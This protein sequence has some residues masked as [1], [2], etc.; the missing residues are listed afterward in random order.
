[1]KLVRWM[2][3]SWDLSKLPAE[4]N[5]LDARY[6]IRVATKEE[7]P[8]VRNVI[9]SAFALDMNWNDS[10]RAIRL[11]FDQQLDEAFAANPSFCLVVTHGV[12]IIAASVVL[13]SREADSQLVSGPCVLSEYRNRGI[14]TS[15]L[16]A[17]LSALREA[18][19]NSAHAVTKANVPVARF[20]YTKFQSTS[21]PWDFEITAA[22]S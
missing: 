12:R 8:V 17:S 10:L 1:M 15:L 3:F 19:F 6:R 11:S 18:G 21:S 9:H 2:R 7:E 4:K 22:A 14:G 16:Y 13:A 20:V 5:P